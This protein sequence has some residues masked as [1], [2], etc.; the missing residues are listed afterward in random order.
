MA[1]LLE[2]M[3]RNVNVECEI[4]DGGPRRPP[5]EFP[6]RRWMPVIRKDAIVRLPVHLEWSYR[7]RRTCDLSNRQE[8]KFAYKQ[9][10]EHGAARD[11][12]FWID[13][14]LL[15]ECYG[16]IPIAPY[17]CEGFLRLI[18]RLKESA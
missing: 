16:E 13:P 18:E 4:I 10:L 7:D 3:E 12:C 9:V 6:I 8:R 5:V 11:I 17:A 1:Q 15:V 14:D 2:E